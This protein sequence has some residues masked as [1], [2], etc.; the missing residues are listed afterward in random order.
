LP[1]D[2]HPLCE[3][4]EIEELPAE[5]KYIVKFI[6]YRDKIDEADFSPTIDLKEQEKINLPK[7]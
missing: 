6:D 1:I 5:D 4:L 2:V 3:V 7:L